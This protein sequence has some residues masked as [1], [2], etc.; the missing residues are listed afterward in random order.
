M[1]VVNFK[2]TDIRVVEHMKE[3][4]S[5]CANDDLFKRWYNKSQFFKAI[6]NEADGVCNVFEDCAELIGSLSGENS[7]YCWYIELYDLEKSS[8]QDIAELAS[9]VRD[10]LPSWSSCF[11]IE[12]KN[13]KIY[14]VATDE[15]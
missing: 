15:D 5:N 11:F 3:L 8:A 13:G 10:D 14:F 1:K 4:A 6:T 7:H 2:G 9:A 12:D